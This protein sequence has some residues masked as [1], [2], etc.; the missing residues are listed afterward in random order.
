M[1]HEEVIR[2]ALAPYVRAQGRRE[3]AADKVYA[4]LVEA[5]AVLDG[6]ATTVEVPNAR[7]P[8][9]T[10]RAFG[11]EIEVDTFG[12]AVRV[13]SEYGLEVVEYAPVG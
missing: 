8:V 11:L 7:V 10:V 3:E 1:D 13:R 2:T 4:A 12:N 9:E 5:G 6:T